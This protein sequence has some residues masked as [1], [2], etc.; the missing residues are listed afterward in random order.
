MILIMKKKILIFT[1]TYNEVEN[2]DIFLHKVLN[3]NI[4]L[5]I[6]VVDDNSPDG[7]SDLVKEFSQNHKNIFLIKREGKL[8]LDSAHKT[9]H[10]FAKSKNY[11]YLITLDADLSHDPAVIPKFIDNLD[12]YP[13][14][15]GSRYIPGGKC[16]ISFFRY[17][18]SYVGNKFIK[19]VLKINSNEFTT[20]FRGFN[21]KLLDKFEINRISSKGYSFFMETISQISDLGYQIYEIPIHFKPR[22]KGYSKIPP[23]E[24]IRTLKNL[25]LLRIKK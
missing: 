7:T 12:K 16:E 20:S 14:V 25:F 17:L 23:I 9:G 19:F 18:L 6:L 24:I 13:F 11:D 10:E 15:I 3:L 22:V 8:G 4:E 1:A 2:I 21:Y 5:D